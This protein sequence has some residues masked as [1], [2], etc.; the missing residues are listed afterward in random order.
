MNSLKIY[1]K[2]Y[3]YI[4]ALF[5]IYFTISF[6]YLTRFPF[7][8][9]DEAWL[10]GLS[11]NILEKKDFATTEAF[12]DLKVRNPH[13]IKILFHLMQMI[14]IKIFDYSIWSMRLL[15]LSFGMGALIIFY[16]LCDFILKSKLYAFLGT[17]L[18]ALDVQFVYATHFARQEIVLLFLFLLAFYYMI[19]HIENHKYK[20]DIILAI[21]IGLCI[22]VHPNSFMIALPFGFIY[23]YHITITKR[24]KL[25]NLMLFV[26][27]LGLLAGLFVGLSFYL[28]PN[29]IADYSRYGE[30]FDVLS[31][32]TSKIGGI[33]NFYL[34]LYYMVSGTYYTPNIKLQF[35]LFSAGF[36]GSLIKLFS[37]FKKR[38][39]RAYD[40]NV[41]VILAIIAINVGIVIIG[42]FNQTCIIFEFPLF[43]I[44]ILCRI[45]SIPWRYKIII[46]ILLIIVTAGSTTLN[47]LPFIGK[48][49]DSYLTQISKVVNKKDNVL[50]NLNCDYYFNNGKLHDYRNLYYLKDH[51]LTFAQYIKQENI[52]Y[53]IYPEEMDIIYR[54]RPIWNGIY[55]NLYYYYEDMLKF[56]KNNCELDYQ[57]SDRTYGMRIAPYINKKA[58]FIKIYKVKK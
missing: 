39:S 34:K 20:S 28:D 42:R 51:N 21:I 22:G 27:P 15:S 11:R 31:P 29:F 47:A 38:T 43:Y 16:K 35:I 40:N 44:L 53:I 26:I 9:S 3:W 18:L 10:S 24:L 48:S 45:K 4:Y 55:G 12:F 14:F 36:V 52:K 19:G 46:P 25:R 41:E 54:D 56:M 2:K 7:V 30:E 1:F 57:F 58:Y 23:I 37:A 6:I 33:K 49:Y 32:M 13:A 5:I 50:A 8:H 17:V